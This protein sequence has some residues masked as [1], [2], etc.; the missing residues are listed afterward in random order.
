VSLRDDPTA[1]SAYGGYRFDDEGWPAAPLALIER[2]VMRGPMCDA[3]SAAALRRPRTGH[4]R[5]AGP[6]DAVEA[7]PSHLVLAPGTRE[8]E[9]LIAAVDGQGY[10]IESGVEGSGDPQSWRVA[11]RARRAREIVGGR[12]TGRVYGPVVVSGDVAPMLSAVRALDRAPHV[13]GWRER[14]VASSTAAP[15]L[16]TRAWVRGQ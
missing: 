9:E 16:L 7:R 4:G 5:R 15:S 11:V 10:L 13:Y 14:G 1:A 3:A 6:L 12:L 8:R 2:G